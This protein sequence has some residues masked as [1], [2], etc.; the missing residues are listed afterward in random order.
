MAKCGTVWQSVAQCGKVW[1]SMAKCGKVWHSVGQCGKVWQRV[2]K[3]GTDLLWHI[4]VPFPCQAKLGKM[5]LVL[6]IASKQQ[7]WSN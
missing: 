3:C 1:H 4:T 6:Y 7:A 5:V 2:A